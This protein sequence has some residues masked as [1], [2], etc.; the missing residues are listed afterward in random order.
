V[1]KNFWGWWNITSSKL[2]PIRPR[3]FSCYLFKGGRDRWKKKKRRSGRR[4]EKT[5][6][7]GAQ[8]TKVFEPS[9]SGGKAVGFWKT[10]N[11][12]IRT[13]SKK[14]DNVLIKIK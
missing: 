6:R 2:S 13:S 3:S 8:K 4:E 10:V 11:Q 1:N 5:R 12:E 7:T 9:K 14:K